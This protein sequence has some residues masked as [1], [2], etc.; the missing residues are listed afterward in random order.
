MSSKIIKADNGI[1]VVAP[2]WPLSERIR[3]FT[4]TRQGGVSQGAFSG[5]NLSLSSSDQKEDVLENRARLKTA[6]NI[7]GTYFALT[8]IHS[9]L[10]VPIL[11]EWNGA[12]ADAAYTESANQPAMILTADCLPILI[13]NRQES[14]VT[15]IHAGWR[16]LLMDIIENSF[17]ALNQ[18]SEDLFVWLGPA[19]SQKAFEIGPEVK[20]AFQYRNTLLHNLEERERHHPALFLPSPN[21]G[22][23]LADIYQLAKLRLKNLGV[24]K[25]QIYGGDLC[26]YSDPTLFYSYRRD[27]VSSGRMASYIWRHE[28]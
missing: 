2:S 3:A 12:G 11:P 1:V 20:S 6:F 28:A 7:P 16:S 18:K 13:T 22:K 14:I 15:A 17:Q 19:I 23:Y 9:N 26:T 8:Q 25:A 5:L 4:T 24:P 10:C 27:G 21:K